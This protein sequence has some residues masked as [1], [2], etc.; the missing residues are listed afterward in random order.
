MNAFRFHEGGRGKA[1]PLQCAPAA[2][3]VGKRVRIGGTCRVGVLLTIPTEG[4]VTLAQEWVMT[5]GETKMFRRGIAAGT[6][7]GLAIG[8][9]L[10]M[11]VAL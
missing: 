9:I 8:L 7:I 6:M 5:D 4:I 1:A 3:V 10:A 2:T 11:F